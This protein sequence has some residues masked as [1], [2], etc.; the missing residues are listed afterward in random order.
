MSE[1]CSVEGCESPRRSK[2]LCNK[3]YHR[4]RKVEATE[5][6]EGERQKLIDEC[7]RLV[8]AARN[9]ERERLT[10]MLPPADDPDIFYPQ[11]RLEQTHLRVMA[12]PDRTV[13]SFADY[14][15]QQA[16]FVPVRHFTLRATQHALILPT[17]QKVVWFGWELA[18]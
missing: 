8:K 18:R 15:F 4:K 1:C 6:A 12:M 5:R 7:H 17:G 2:G 13:R 3:H 11:G 14:H 16:A 9:D 10:T